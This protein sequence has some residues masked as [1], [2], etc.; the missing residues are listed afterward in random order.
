MNK[1]IK[2]IDKIIC[3][4]LTVI[5]ICSFNTL[6][7]A[8]VNEVYF[9]GLKLREIY[10]TPEDV[11]YWIVDA[12][13]KY[14]I[15]ELKVP[16][17]Y[18]N[19]PITAIYD[20]TKPGG[21]LQGSINLQKVDLSSSNIEIIGAYC[22]NN[23]L[24]LS[25][26]KSSK[27]LK[28]VLGYAFKGAN[29]KEL[30]LYDGLE[31]IK[32]SAFEDAFSDENELYVI[33]IPDSVTSIGENAFKVTDKN[34]RVVLVGEKNSVVEKYCKTDSTCTFMERGDR[35][36]TAEEILDAEI[37][38]E[39]SKLF[40]NK[41]FTY[42]NYNNTNNANTINF[43]ALPASTLTSNNAEE[44]LDIIKVDDGIIVVGYSYLYKYKSES[45]YFQEKYISKAK[46][47]DDAIILKY[48]NKLNMKTFKCFGGSGGDRF[49]KIY[50]TKDG[51]YLVL[52]KTT[53]NDKDL[54]NINS[55]INT[56]QQ[57]AVKYDRNLNVVFTEMGYHSDVLEKY[58]NQILEDDEGK[59]SNGRI[60]LK[61]I[62]SDQMCLAPGAYVNER[63]T[64]ITKYDNQE[65]KEWIKTFNRG[66]N[67]SFD[68]L[69]KAIEI[70]D[71]YVF[72]GTSARY[73][74]N[75][76]NTL[77]YVED[78]IIIKY[79]KPYDQI[80]ING[81]IY[82][83]DIGTQK[84]ADVFYLP[85][86]DA[87]IGDMKWTSENEDIA[88]VDYKGNITA[89]KEGTTKIHLNVRGKEAQILINVTDPNIKHIENITL[90]KSECTLEKGK[91]E[92]LIATI[93]PTDTT[94]D[95]TISWTSSNPNVATVDSEGLVTAVGSGTATITATVGEKSATC[96]VTVP[97]EQTTKPGEGE[98]K[99][100]ESEKPTIDY[101]LGDVDGNKKVD[102]Q[103]A[104]MILKYV[105]HNITLTD[106]QLLAANT[107]KDKDGTVDAQD[108]V[109]ILKYV[110][111]NITEF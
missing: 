40:E 62:L 78:A 37:A 99:P 33:N 2:L 4:V 92:T 81:A 55:N 79:N 25:E 53:S 73:I 69:T 46:G 91:S 49:E 89:K 6:S 10:Y 48:D 20:N 9:S 110:A 41:E 8:R 82:A 68:T 45:K 11:R 67:S 56:Y 44:Y 107:T 109:Q 90:N 65:H 83:M 28:E 13:N 30:T 98:T 74:E 24:K 100:G 1:N 7:Y 27:C 52:G 104:V 23:C 54:L 16:A 14:T 84:K 22:F 71:G 85:W 94:D 63:R 87:T 12:T 5:I 105:A 66:A 95:K 18:N 72:I 64:L 93:N 43:F 21:L 59:I 29:L 111:H 3:I 19:I 50:K 51:G 101:L 106:K 75:Q 42:G 88:T 108:A 15:A 76:N 36:P 102:A 32:I 38:K 26:F 80:I 96:T 60:E 39:K 103:D 57:M 77:I 17:T 58:K 35:V 97:K 34:Y 47:N 61:T 86:E 31:T 70:D